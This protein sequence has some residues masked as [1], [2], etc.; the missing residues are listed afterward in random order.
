MGDIV[1]FGKYK[2]QPVE[3]LSA[4]S[5]YAAWL[6]GQGWIKDKFPQFYT[7]IVNNFG[8]VEDTP[9]HNALQA[10][11]LS[12]DLCIQLFHALAMETRLHRGE[13]WVP[14]RLLLRQFEPVGA[15]VCLSLAVWEWCEY[16]S[17]SEWFGNQYRIVVEIKPSIGDDFPGILRG[18]RDLDCRACVVCEHYTGQGATFEQVREMFR[19][20]DVILVTFAELEAMPT[21]LFPDRPSVSPRSYKDG[22]V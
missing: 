13:Y 19:Q 10:R 16:D 8:E 15:D 12:D 22:I 11:F 9:E 17:A 5:D 20:S 21:Q 3:V 2:G 1:P 18:L 7:L 4:D 14:S 6:H